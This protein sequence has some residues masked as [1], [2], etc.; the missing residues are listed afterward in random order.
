LHQDR[1]GDDQVFTLKPDYDETK[2]RIEAFWERELIDRPVVQFTLI[3]PPEERVPLPPSGHATSEARWLDAEYQ[4]ELAVATLQNYEF[5]GDTLPV[6]FPNLGPEIFSAFYGCPMHFGDYG[7]S[8]SDPILE[9]WEQPD[10]IQLDWNSPYLRKLHEMTDLLL[11]AGEGLFITGMTDWHP[12]GDCVAAFRDPQNLALDMLLYPEGVRA[13]LTRVE[14]DYFRMY[15]VFYEKLR[16]AGQPISTW[17]TLMS[18]GK[19]YVPSNDFSIMISQ[20]MFDDMFL[21]GIA[22]ECEF[23]DRSIYH[24]DGPGALRHFDSLMAIE[25]LDALQ[26][27]PGAGNEGFHRWIDVYRRAQAAGKGVQVFCD[28][29]EL[30]LVMET[31]DPRGLFLSVSKVPDRASAQA[32]LAD[33]QTWCAQRAHQRR[34]G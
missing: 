8:W 15:D 16:A 14:A 21:P 32:M 27:V 10:Q 29:D 31:L 5:L 3:K 4:T 34:S 18:D 23:L 22:R 2:Q 20:Q 33:L 26:F 25:A 11:E 1:G 17:L 6:A 7:T 24:L 28:L 9:D 12:G 19:Y 30:P 13:L